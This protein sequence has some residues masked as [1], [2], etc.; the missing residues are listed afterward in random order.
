MKWLLGAGLS[1]VGL[2][3]PVAAGEA[4]VHFVDDR[5][6]PVV[7]ELEVCLI[8]GLDTTCREVGPGKRLAEA[9]ESTRSAPS[10]RISG[11]CTPS[12]AS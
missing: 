9:G 4:E 11:P 5:G 8:A 3:A 1:L 7:E 12:A 6:Q 10:R 2:V